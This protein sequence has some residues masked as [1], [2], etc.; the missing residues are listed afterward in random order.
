[1]NNYLFLTVHSNVTIK[2]ISWP[3]FSWATLYIRKEKSFRATW[4]RSTHCEQFRLGNVQDANDC[5]DCRLLELLQQKVELCRPSLPVFQFDAWPDVVS[6]ASH[7][8]WFRQNLYQDIINR[9]NCN[10]TVTFGYCH[11]MSSVVVICCL[12]AKYRF[13]RGKFD[14]E[15]RS[16]S[17]LIIGSNQGA[18]FAELCLGNG[19]RY[20]LGQN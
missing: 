10:C 16:I 2:N 5:S 4:K 12:S 13:F 8:L 14:D 7:L 1:M 6:L 3:Y 11:D 15:I 19:E 18:D 20:S 9:S 17:R